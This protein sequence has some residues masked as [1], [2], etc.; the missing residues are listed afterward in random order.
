MY[1]LARMAA[2]PLEPEEVS[3]F[4]ARSQKLLGMVAGG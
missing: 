2:R 3:A 1:D 4:L